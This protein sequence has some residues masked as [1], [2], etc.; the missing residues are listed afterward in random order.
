MFEMR[1][2]SYPS[3]LLYPFQVSNVVDVGEPNE[4][5]S[6]LPIYVFGICTTLRHQL[7]ERY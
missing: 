3:S 7:A 6:V 5:I 2:R 4:I 1:N